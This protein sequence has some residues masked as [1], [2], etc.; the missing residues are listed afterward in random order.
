MWRRARD[1]GRLA[2]TTGRTRRQAAGRLRRSRSAGRASG[3]RHSRAALCAP[4]WRGTSD[5]NIILF[6]TQIKHRLRTP[7][8]DH[9][10]KLKVTF[11]VRGVTSPLVANI[12]L[13]LA[14]DDWMRRI[15]PGVP[16]ERYADDIV[17]HCGTET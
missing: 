17:A 11:C 4:L 13:H 15:H 16:F 10:L 5:I 9:A 6:T 12:F 8:D 14:F 7:S 2:A 1:T 3:R